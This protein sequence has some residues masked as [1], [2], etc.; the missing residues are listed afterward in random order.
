[1][2]TVKKAGFD[3]KQK[4]RLKQNWEYVKKEHKGKEDIEHFINLCKKEGREGNKVLK[5][6]FTNELGDSIKKELE[7]ILHNE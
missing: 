7:N 6:K 1:M 4:D 2:S 5:G 3:E